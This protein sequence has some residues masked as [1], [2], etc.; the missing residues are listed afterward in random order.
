MCSTAAVMLL[1]T[2]CS[3][4]DRA[5]R[6]LAEAV[7]LDLRDPARLTEAARHSD[8]VVMMVA[9]TLEPALMFYTF[10]RGSQVGC[11]RLID[12]SNPA[13]GVADWRIEG[14]CA[15]RTEDE[16]HVSKGS[17]VGRGD[18]RGTR[19][20]YRGFRSMVSRPEDCGGA[21]IGAALDGVVEV[22]YLLAPPRAGNGP[23]EPEETGEGR[24]ALHLYLE[25]WGGA[26]ADHACVNTRTQ[27]AYDVTIDHWIEPAQDARPDR[28]AGEVRTLAYQRKL[29]DVAGRVAVHLETRPSA[30]AAWAQAARSPGAWD[31]RAHA[32]GLAHDGSGACPD[33][34]TGTLDLTS[35]NGV[36]TLHPDASTSC[37][38]AEDGDAQ[39]ACTRWSLNGAAQPEEL[40]GFVWLMDGA[41][42]SAGPDAPPPWAAIALL[43]AGLA[44]QSRRRRAA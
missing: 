6:F 13:A 37:F 38:G 30:A 33:F 17:I 27:M 28:H 8:P 12:H 2:G 23:E 26:E 9:G 29:Y 22:P 36:A 43:A 15:W 24:Y 14:D 10:G 44:W 34:V 41:G 5:E 7:P 20:E 18:T 1:V 32:Y 3:E 25:R 21:E 39:F 4:P 31:V 16:A 19:I 35:G 11:F 40:C 42:C